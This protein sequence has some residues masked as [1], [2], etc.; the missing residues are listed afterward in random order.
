V[1]ILDALLVALQLLF[2]MLGGAVETRM[3]LG[4]AAFGLEQQSGCEVKRA[5]GVEVA[6]LLLD[7]HMGVHGSFEIALLKLAEAIF[8]VVP[9]RVTD[10]EILTR[11]L[12]LHRCGKIPVSPLQKMGALITNVNWPALAC[13]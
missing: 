2:Q 1:M 10:I 7:R 3:G 8:D 6:T 5:V 11:D 4:S 12:D 13:G 9:E